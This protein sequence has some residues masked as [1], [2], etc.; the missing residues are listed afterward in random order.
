MYL[1]IH[2]INPEK[3]NI[4]LI[5]D[6]LKSGGIIAYPT[7]TIMGLGCDIFQL[8]A[9]EKICKLKNI[10][11]AKAQLSFMCNSLSHL[12]LY[13]KSIST[14]TYRILKSCLPGPYTFILLASKQVPKILQAKKK[15]I[16]IRV[17]NNK[18]ALDII[19]ALG[20][21]VLSTSLPGQEV[22]EYTDPKTVH[23]NFFKQIDLV[24]DGGIGGIIPSTVIDCTDTVPLV[25]RQGAGQWPVV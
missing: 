6:C 13:S 22:E 10:S 21:P 23:E 11:P 5:I 7:D 14:P 19:E 9:I 1:K 16:G 18:I 4:Q 24:V 15:T 3:R 8:N 12:S 20:N 2:P 17:P 25:I